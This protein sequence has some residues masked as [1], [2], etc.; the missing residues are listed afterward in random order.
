MT[1]CPLKACTLLTIKIVQAGTTLLN[2]FRSE[3]GIASLV[4]KPKY[5]NSLYPSWLRSHPSNVAVLITASVYTPVE[6]IT[7]HLMTMRLMTLINSRTI[8]LLV[9]MLL[10]YPIQ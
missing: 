9:G 8:L 7:T 10:N 3:P 4:N 5:P 2:K 1:N 6:T